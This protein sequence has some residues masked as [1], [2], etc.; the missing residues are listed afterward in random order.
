MIYVADVERA[1]AFYH[2]HLGFR[3]IS[4]MEGYARLKSPKGST[5]IA[6][7]QYAAGA[8]RAG[9]RAEGLRLYFEVDGLD[10]LC[11]R[12][13]RKGVR[14]S[15]MPE[16]MPWGWRHAYLKDPDGHE[17][18]ATAASR[19]MPSLMFSSDACEKL[20]RICVEPRPSK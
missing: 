14:F 8:K 7:H 4:K 20:S 6:L 5:T 19:S 3:V 16:D 18:S 2:G 15:R 1:L 17:I 13:K 10:A 9:R 11:A 12:M